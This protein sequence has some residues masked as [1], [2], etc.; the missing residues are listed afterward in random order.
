MMATTPTCDL[1]ARLLD[2]PPGSSSVVVFPDTTSQAKNVA[3]CMA[4]P[5]KAFGLVSAGTTLL[6]SFSVLDNLRL[7]LLYHQQPLTHADADLAT[8]CQLAG[9]EARTL[10]GRPVAA[11][12]RLER[13]QATFLQAALQRPEMLLCDGIFEGLGAAE[14]QQAARLIEAFHRLFPLRRSAYLG[15]AAPPVELYTPTLWIDP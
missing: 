6:E 10:L 11:T 12:S 2:Q 9:I 3:R 7:P 15:V 8:L 5:R 14:R 4:H 13:I 1:H